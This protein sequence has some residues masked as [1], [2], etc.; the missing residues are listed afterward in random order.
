M[1]FLLSLNKKVFLIFSFIFIFLILFI[2]SFNFFQPADNHLNKISKNKSSSDISEPKFS[3]N[4]KK[5]KISVTANEG[6]FLTDNEIV[7]EKNVIFK[8]NKFKIY[9]DNVI[10][11]KKTLVASSQESSKFISNNTSIDSA[12][13]DIIDNGN[14]INFKGKTKLIL[15]W[16]SLYFFFFIVLINYK[17][18]LARN[19]GETEITT[20]DGIEVFQ[21]EKYY[22][23]KKNVEIVSDEFELNGNLV[24]IFFD[25]D[26][27]DI[28]EL[29]ASTDV[30]FISKT[31]DIKG[32]GETLTFN[33]QNEQIKV[34]GIGSELFLET[35]EMFSDGSITVNN[36]AGSFSIKGH[37]S[38]LI[39]DEIFITGFIINGIL[40]NKEGN[41][42]ISNLEVQDENTL[43]IFTEDTEMFSKKAFYDKEKSIIELFDNVKIIRGNEMITGD[44][45]VLNTDKNTY[46]VSS[47][48]SNKVKAIITNTK[49][50]NSNYLMTV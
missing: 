18:A 40:V 25:K 32:K 26:L 15:K 7:L 48:N 38:K 29:T 20:E 39:T 13:F 50:V 4:S 11:N 3:I 49:W 44:Y 37:N 16:L 8:S 23:L 1:N 47:K 17:T 19:I 30:K 10:F 22:L 41:R 5:Q 6:N 21:E 24:K 34:A 12:G 36:I 45:G 27:Y 31:N 35:T 14:I 42:I 43:N 2:F 46:K 9:T 33:I 28:Q